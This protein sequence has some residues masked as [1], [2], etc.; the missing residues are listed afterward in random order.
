RL[1]DVIDTPSA[2][3]TAEQPGPVARLRQMLGEI[4][5]V[6]E[7]RQTNGTTRDVPPAAFAQGAA[8]RLGRS[9]D[10]DRGLRWIVFTSLDGAIAVQIIPARTHG[11][12]GRMRAPHL[13]LHGSQPM[14]L[15]DII[16]MQDVNPLQ[17]IRHLL[18]GPVDVAPLALIARAVEHNER[19]VGSPDPS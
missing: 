5:N 11:A 13:P 15:R 3:Q 1:R 12:N 17:I 7:S 8:D 14:R 9:V 18:H 16:R 19:R 4:P 10:V 6:A 2:L